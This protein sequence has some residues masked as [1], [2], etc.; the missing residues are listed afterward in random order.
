MVYDLDPTPD[1]S[2]PVKFRWPIQLFRISAL[3]GS[4]E[5]FIDQQTSY[6][7][8]EKFFFQ[9]FPERVSVNNRICGVDDD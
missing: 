6:G 9:V 2:L 1:S 4:G 7:V 3:P 8:S 5:S